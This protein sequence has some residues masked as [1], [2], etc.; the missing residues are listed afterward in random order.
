MRLATMIASH[1]ANAGDVVGRLEGYWGLGDNSMS[2]AINDMA[3]V[4]ASSEAAIV[5]AVVFCIVMCVCA[6][7]LRS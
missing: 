6:C 1:P 5:V 7:V 2:L 4:D 3:V